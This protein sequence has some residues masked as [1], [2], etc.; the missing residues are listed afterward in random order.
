MR[1]LLAELDRPEGDRHGAGAFGVRVLSVRWSS[2]ETNLA[3]VAAR[4]AAAGIA[5]LAD[6]AVEGVS[7]G[8]TEIVPKTWVPRP[9]LPPSVLPDHADVDSATPAGTVN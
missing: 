5:A 1:S 6:T 7:P 4:A 9:P 2:V 3:V 8:V